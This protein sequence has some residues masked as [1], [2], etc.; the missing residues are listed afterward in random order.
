MITLN[1]TEREAAILYLQFDMLTNGGNRNK[2]L[3]AVFGKL[4]QSL[5]ASQNQDYARKELRFNIL[6][7]LELSRPINF[8]LR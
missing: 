2:V 8:K 7:E 4:E 1:L 6:S 3:D 5:L